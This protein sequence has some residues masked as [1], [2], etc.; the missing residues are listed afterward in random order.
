M[1]CTY[2]DFQSNYLMCD[3]HLSWVVKWIKETNVRVNSDTKCAV[4][5]DMKDRPVKALKKKDLH[6][7]KYPPT[8]RLIRKVIYLPL[9][10]KM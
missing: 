8:S 5:K 1:F 4:P 7:S 9:N 3:C 2:R 10:L 6:C